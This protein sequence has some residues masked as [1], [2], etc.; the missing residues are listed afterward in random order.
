MKVFWKDVTVVETPGG[1]GIALDG[2]EMKTPARAALL[3][4]TLALA[5]AVADEW[6]DQTDEVRPA[7]MPLTRSANSAID[8]VVQHREAVI[9]ELAGYGGTDLI[10]YRAPHPE[11]L[12][13]RQAEGWDPLVAWAAEDLGAPL[14]LTAGVMH[15]AQPAGSLAALARAVAAHDAWALTALHGLV[16]LSGSLVIGLGVSH[17]Q[18][19]PA[20]AWALSRIDEQWNIEEWGAD[21]EAARQ[22]AAKEADFHVAARLLALLKT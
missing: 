4:P 21:A 3:L 14:K 13:A 7:A 20:E 9:D 2:R 16:T 5:E 11:A 17:G 10:C 22:A 19:T 6:R 12:A 1:H 8:R 15:L 18:L